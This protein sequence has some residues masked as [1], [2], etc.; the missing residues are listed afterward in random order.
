M[1]MDK[2]VAIRTNW[3]TKGSPPCSHPEVEKERYLGADTGDEVCTKCGTA[4]PR[5][6]LRRAG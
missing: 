6:S 5:G 1:Q 3:E 2:A 4:G